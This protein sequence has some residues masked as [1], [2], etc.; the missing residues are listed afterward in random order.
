MAKKI[1]FQLSGSISAFK[2]C[3][4]ISTLVKAGHEVQIAVSDSALKFIGEAT[5]EGL[6]GRAVLKGTFEPG[7]M[8]G[9][10]HH[11]RWAD[12]LVLCPASANTLNQLANGTGDSLL[13]TLFLAHDFKKPYLV[14]P[15]MNTTMYAHPATQASMEKLKSWGV[16]VFDTGRGNLACGEYGEGR[17]LEP[18]QIYKHVEKYL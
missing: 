13:S 11:V 1:L 3:A 10:I 16:T 14:F 6:T 18:E 12:F 17:L 4:V 8:M 9:H 15:A 5:L 2:A 7:Q